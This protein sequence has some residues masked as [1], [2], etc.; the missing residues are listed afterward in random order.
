VTESD[1]IVSGAMSPTVV[2]LHGFG[3][4]S[5]TT[6]GDNGW[7]DL[8]GDLGFDVLAIDLLGHG[9][10][11]KPHDPAAY[12]ELEALVRDQLPPGPLYGVGFSLGARVLLTLASDEPERFDRLVVAGVGDNLFRGDDPEALAMLVEGSDAPAHPMGHYFQ[13]LARAPGSDA[14]ALAAYLRRPNPP[15][16]SDGSLARITSPTLVVLG[17]DDFAGPAQP[18]VDRL[19][20]ARLVE[21]PGVDH[22]ATP[23]TFGFIDAALDFLAAE[24]VGGGSP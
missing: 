14:V 21:L 11:P 8:L 15:P 10:A 6:W 3:T 19:P 16:L 18:L 5:R 13:Q 20:D 9:S 2:L 7:I 1:P 12:D 4:S 23:K 24:T 17:T 22:F